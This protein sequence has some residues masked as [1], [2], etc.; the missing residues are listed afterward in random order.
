MG[1]EHIAASVSVAAL[2][3][4]L[5]HSPSATYLLRAVPNDFVLEAVNAKARSIS[6]ALSTM[7][8]RPVSLLYRD[9]PEIIGDA[10][11]CLHEKRPVIR[12]I[13]VRRHDRAEANQRQRLTFVFVEP[14]L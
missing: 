2:V 11:R 10:W 4:V 12:E 9:Q 13:S 8:G 5:E 7:L 1:S 14:D 3:E 6:P